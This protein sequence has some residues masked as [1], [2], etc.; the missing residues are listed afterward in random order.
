MKQ[1]RWLLRLASLIL[2]KTCSFH[3][4]RRTAQPSGK[5]RPVYTAG[6]GG[7]VENRGAPVCRLH[8][9][10]RHVWGH[11]ECSRLSQVI[12]Y[13]AEMTHPCW[14]LFNSLIVISNTM[15]VV[16]KHWILCFLNEAWVNKT[17]IY[18]NDKKS[19]MIVLNIISKL[20]CFS[21]GNTGEAWEL[22]ISSLKEAENNI[23]KYG[24]VCQST[25]QSDWHIGNI[26]KVYVRSKKG[27]ILQ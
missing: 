15:V 1:P 9:C 19:F 11:L 16:L 12:P 6:E 7:Q 5:K 3:F 13:R 26:Q 14:V 10:S 27:K 2:K 23:M 25:L 17:V 22:L 18:N 20:N 8:Q 21:S 24:T 4:C